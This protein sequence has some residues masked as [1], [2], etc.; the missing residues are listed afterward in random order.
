M[1]KEATTTKPRAKASCYVMMRS[2]P[3]RTTGSRRWHRDAAAEGNLPK[4][5]SIKVGSTLLPPSPLDQSPHGRRRPH[6][7]CR[8]SRRSPPPWP[9]SRPR[10]F[11]ATAAPHELCPAMPQAAAGGKACMGGRRMGGRVPR[12]DTAAAT[13]G[14]GWLI[15]VS[16]L[17]IQAS[18]N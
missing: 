12:H 6:H 18:D 8:W 14:S 17:N 16:L 13:Q 4:P 2:W 9:H 15:C 10:R 1:K 11:T 5:I 7:C 3:R